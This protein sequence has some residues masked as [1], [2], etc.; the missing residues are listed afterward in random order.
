MFLHLYTC[1][2]LTSVKIALRIFMCF[3][4]GSYFL[5]SDKTTDDRLIKQSLLD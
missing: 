1:I 2:V 5:T 3:N 4:E